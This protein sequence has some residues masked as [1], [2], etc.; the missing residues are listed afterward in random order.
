MENILNNSF[1]VQFI[2]TQSSR[3]LGRELLAQ[4]HDVALPNEQSDDKPLS[5]AI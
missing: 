1:G 3:A 4:K 5:Q 2:S